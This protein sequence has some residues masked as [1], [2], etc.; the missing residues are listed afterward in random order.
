MFNFDKTY[1]V[2][3]VPF[4][5]AIGTNKY[6]TLKD[7]I[8][9]NTIGRIPEKLFAGVVGI[10]LA[11]AL[12]FVGVDYKNRE[13][14]DPGIVT[15]A[16]ASGHGPRPTINPYNGPGSRPVTPALHED[17]VARLRRS[18]SDSLYTVNYGD[19]FFDNSWG[20]GIAKRHWYAE[21][22][23][24]VISENDKESLA[25]R[26]RMMINYL[27]EQGLDPENL[28]EGDRI[29]LLPDGYDSLNEER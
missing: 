23:E 5:M 11:G 1:I 2:Y 12:T 16:E 13:V 21:Y 19:T 4:Y 15:L 14:E 22:G 24:R 17:Y 9:D 10:A 27:K 18:F 26:T 25:S 6:D 7:R 8:W 3:T 28:K 29:D 20:P